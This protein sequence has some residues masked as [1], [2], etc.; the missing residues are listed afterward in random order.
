MTRARL[1]P[2]LSVSPVTRATLAAG[3]QLLWQE[4]FASVGAAVRALGLLGYAGDDDL[5][6]L[7]WLCM[8]ALGGDRRWESGRYTLTLEEVQ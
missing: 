5:R 4:H 1:D 8:T 7:S 3:E 6:R 2:L